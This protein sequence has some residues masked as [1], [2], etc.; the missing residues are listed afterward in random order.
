MCSTRLD[1]IGERWAY[2]TEMRQ[3]WLG[4]AERATHRYR[5]G[6]LHVGL[7]LEEQERD[8]GIAL[9]ARPKVRQR[10]TSG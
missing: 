5:G 10:S 6:S 7:V 8:L 3:I 2:V 9:L 1:Q 4:G